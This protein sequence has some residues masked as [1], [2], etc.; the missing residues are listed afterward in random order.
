MSRE[1][2]EE[3]VVNAYRDRYYPSLSPSTDTDNDQDQ[4]TSTPAITMNATLLP[5]ELVRELL[6]PLILVPEAKFFNLN[7]VSSFALPILLRLP[8]F[9]QAM[10]AR[11]HPTALRL[12]RRVIQ[13]SSPCD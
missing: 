10:D 2:Q 3:S 13:S 5:D 12:H 4:S 8:S 6:A 9:M 11:C 7:D 1:R